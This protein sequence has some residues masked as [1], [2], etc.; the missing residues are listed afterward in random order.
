MS[1]ITDTRNADLTFAAGDVIAYY[2]QLGTTPP[3]GF[4]AVTSP[5]ICLG[6]VDVTGAIF[7]LS[8]TIKDVMAA[9]TLDPIR[10]I[11]SA[12]P[13]TFD[14]TFMEGLNPAVRALYDDVLLT[15]LQPATGTTV[16]T[17]LTPEI[18]TDN[19][20]CFLFD[21]IDGDKAM[22]NFCVNAKVTN[23]GNDQQQQL[24]AET[25]Q[26]TVTLYPDLIGSTRSAMQR[27]IDYGA[28]DLTPFFA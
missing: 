11:T 20:Y 14:L 27:Y 23:R 15:E 12:A 1:L 7:K 6:W 8:E 19:R 9:G 24:D 28:A 16:A 25:I 2:S 21:T 17:Y 10:T 4:A 13:K 26:L 22:R 18:P 5:W 3:V